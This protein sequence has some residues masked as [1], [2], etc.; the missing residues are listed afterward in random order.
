MEK[1][2]KKKGLV[3]KLIAAET[4]GSTSV[5]C[6]DKTGT[7]TEGKM[8]VAEIQVPHQI[9]YHQNSQEKTYILA[10]KIAGLCSEAFIENL[11]QPMEKWVVRGRPTDKALLLAAIQSGINLKE[12]KT[13]EPKIDEIPFDSVYKYSAA[14][15]QLDDKE[16]IIYL[17]GAPEV[18]LE[19]SKFL[20]ID[21]SQKGIDPEK[22]KKIQKK[23]TDLTSRGFRVVAASY[24]KI[25]EEKKK[26]SDKDLQDMVF[27]GFIVLHDPIRKRAKKAIETCRQAGMKPIIVTG[28]HKL[29]AKAVAEELGFKIKEENILEG[30]D[31]DKLSD[32]EFDKILSQIQIYARVEPKHKMRIIGAWQDKGEVVAMTG[33]GV[34]DA[35]ALKK[36]DIGVALGSGTEV[37]KEASDLTL[38]TDDF[39][40][41]IVAIEEGR[42]IIDN[43]RKIITYLLIGGFTE[44][45]LIGLSII[46]HLPLP[47][48]AG[49]ILWKNLIESTPPSM[50]LSVEPKE[51]GI[52]TRKPEP[53]NLP[54]LTKQMKFLIFVIGM[55]M[56]IFLFL[57][58]IWF[59]KN[60]N[61]GI[62][63]IAQIRTLIFAGLG[64][65]SFF[66]IFSF[67]NLRQ[68][69][70]QYN[71]F[72]NLYVVIAALAGF[73]L[74]LAAIYLPLLQ[75]L[76]GTV[77]LGLF[78]W[79]I[80]FIY[81]L[82]TLFMIEIAK[83]Y[84][85]KKLRVKN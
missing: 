78:E 73:L 43:F 64:I 74:L 27:V 23:Y 24:K 72:S 37:A 68:N 63:K 69:I 82:I 50:A 25:K 61:Y 38:L 83:W 16:K 70:W 59:L 81:A 67:R 75:F 71:P 31:L 79:S 40:I 5:I 2:L 10:L 84:Y 1:N 19:K 58:F 46:F 8:E 9:I 77:P 66:F 30:K 14:L 15:H 22:I 48:L 62:D 20:E 13:K 33:D 47:V 6:T 21:N 42:R 55:I 36:A 35:P 53:Q 11:E 12:I 26:I 4:L 45:M 57:I 51:N 85:I 65:D 76:L 28:D 17:M 49:Q 60:P 7:L 80:I 41:I 34:N 29:T 39:E 32:Y 52:M 54:L 18:I 44:V 56:N 3:R